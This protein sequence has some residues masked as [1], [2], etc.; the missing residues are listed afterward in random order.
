MSRCTVRA[1][2]GTRTRMLSCA[3]PSRTDF[4]VRSQRRGGGVACGGG[5]G[6]FVWGGEAE[7]FFG[8]RGRAEIIEAE[9]VASVAGEHLRDRAAAV[10]G[11]VFF[12]GVAV[13]LDD[14]PGRFPD[15]ILI[16][17]GAGAAGQRGEEGAGGEPVHCDV[18]VGESPTGAA[19]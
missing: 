4:L 18:A 5:R 11:A 6:G 14:G 12:F 1:A 8:G 10:A 19:A 16:R 9:G 17:G 3:A 15:E 13:G 2:L 7:G